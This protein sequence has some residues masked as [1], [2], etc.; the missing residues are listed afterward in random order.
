M[1]EVSK[2]DIVAGLRRLGLA[3]GDE[4]IV[5]SSLKSLGRIAGGPVAVIE[6]FMD[7]LTDA[8]TLMM[9]SFNQG[10][11]FGPGAAGFF[12]PRST[13]TSNGAIPQTFWQMPGV[14]RSL[15]PTHSFAAWGRNGQA[16]TN[17]HHRTLTCGADSPLGRLGAAGGLGVLIGVDYRANTYHH[18]VETIT[19]AP[20]LG[21]RT[22]ALP[23]RLA[24][25]RLVE[26]R[27]WGWRERA[28]PIDDPGRYGSEMKRRGYE[29]QTTVGQGTVTCFRL[30]DC[31]EVVATCL[32]SGMD[33]HPPCSRCPIRPQQTPQTVPSDW[34]E[35]AGRIVPGSSAWL[36]G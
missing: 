29:R 5:H 14:W 7:V 34:D 24:D 4:V 3:A 33:E 20:C 21:R 28:C 6:A 22:V 17:D 11:A 35:A 15:H 30:K 32:A 23:M 1:P 36:C 26:G 9:P 10:K 2:E 8:G 16:Y 19:G 31:F 12:D 13:P 25:G 27:T 18:V